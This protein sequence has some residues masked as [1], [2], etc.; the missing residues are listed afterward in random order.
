MVP[1]P[2]RVTMDIE[3]E[4]DTINST[5][6]SSPHK[7]DLFHESLY[8]PS[9]YS[10]YEQDNTS[11]VILNNNNNSPSFDKDVFRNKNTLGDELKA[12][13]GDG[14]LVHSSSSSSLPRSSPLQHETR[15]Q[16]GPLE[17]SM[18]SHD[19]R[20]PVGGPPNEF[21]DDEIDGGSNSGVGMGLHSTPYKDEEGM[22]FNP[23]EED[24]FMWVITDSDQ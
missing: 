19:S 11:A 24:T 6:V 16:L 23:R 14:D 9:H 5:N 22:V 4:K 21:S 15:P 20:P 10:A 8:H 2:G 3:K 7:N 1:V 13:S 17:D 12:A 18:S